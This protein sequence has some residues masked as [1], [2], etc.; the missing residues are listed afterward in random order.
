MDAYRSAGPRVRSRATADAVEALAD[1]LERSRRPVILAGSG[2]WTGDAGAA[3]RAVAERIGAGVLTT[4]GGRGSFPEDHDAVARP[5]RPLLHERGPGGVG[6][7]R[8]RASASARGSR[9]CRPDRARA[10]SRPAPPTRRSTPTRSRSRGTSCRTS[11]WS[12]TRRWCSTTSAPCSRARNAGPDARAAWA[13]TIADLKAQEAVE[14][15]AARADV[16]GPVFGGQAVGVIEQV[17]GP[18]TILGARERRPRP[19]V[20][21]LAVLPRA[22]RRHL[23][24]ARR[25]DGDGHRR[26]RRD[27]R[28]AGA[29][30][31]CT[32]SARP[33]TA[34]CRCRSASSAPPSRTRRR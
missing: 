28:E 4:P 22:R 18:N 6:S 3:L 1:A 34:R 30:R 32:S 27:R 21:L 15:E 33:A 23:D 29:A 13:A 11:R 31:T 19:V 14:V 12:A 20:V 24:P 5:D 25:A 8:P 9:S 26:G 10:C 17:F 7:G 2:A 16:R